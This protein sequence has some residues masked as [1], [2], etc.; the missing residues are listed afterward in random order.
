MDRREFFEKSGCGLFGMMLAYFGL[1]MPLLADEKKKKMTR[2]EYVMK[3][4]VKK[5]GKSEE[6]AKRNFGD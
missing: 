3:L 6:E 5:M 2:E 1:E 4:L